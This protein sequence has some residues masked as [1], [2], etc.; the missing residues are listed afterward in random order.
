[1]VRRCQAHVVLD[2]GASQEAHQGLPSL[3]AGL[4]DPLGVGRVLTG[5]SPTG[6]SE[7]WSW[8]LTVSASAAPVL[9][10]EG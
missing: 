6:A 10:A 2:V 8:E 4:G 5:Q 3:C 1:M 7:A 9:A